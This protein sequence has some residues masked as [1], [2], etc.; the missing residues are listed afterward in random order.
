MPTGETRSR[1]KPLFRKCSITKQFT[2]T[3]V[4]DAFPDPTA[5]DADVGARLPNLEHKQSTASFVA[6]TR[7][8]ESAEVFVARETAWDAGQLARQVG[9]GDVHA[10]PVA[11]RRATS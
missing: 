4:L 1:G 5:L 6:L 10:A 11:W 3:T 7:Q 9:C 2:C 8:R